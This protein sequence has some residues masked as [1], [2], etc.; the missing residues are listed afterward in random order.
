MAGHLAAIRGRAGLVRLLLDR[1][2]DPNGRDGFYNATLL[3]WALMGHPRWGHPDGRWREVVEVLLA[4]DATVE[5]AWLPDD[6]P[7]ADLLS[8]AGAGEG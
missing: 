7:I 5:G 6:G 8:G 3:Q 4:H 2:A 1:G